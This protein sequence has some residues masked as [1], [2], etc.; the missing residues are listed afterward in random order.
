MS[1]MIIRPQP[2]A[3]TMAERMNPRTTLN[4]SASPKI[5][6]RM[7]M[8]ALPGVVP[9]RDSRMPSSSRQGSQ[10]YT[11]PGNRFGLYSMPSMPT[12]M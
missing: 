7:P 1:G 6:R 12:T 2:S 5:L 9:K 8:S 3:K 11:E 10:T 4:R